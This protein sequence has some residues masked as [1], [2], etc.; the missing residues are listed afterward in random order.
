MNVLDLQAYIPFVR[1]SC[2]NTYMVP[3]VAPSAAKHL[4]T[5]T[6]REDS[7]PGLRAMRAVLVLPDTLQNQ[8]LSKQNNFLARVEQQ[9]RLPARPVGDEYPRRVGG[10]KLANAQRRCKRFTDSQSCNGKRG[11]PRQGPCSREHAH[12]CLASSQPS[13]AQRISS[14]AVS[15]VSGPVG[16]GPS[17]GDIA[18]SCFSCYQTADTLQLAYVAEVTQTKARSRSRAATD[19]D[20]TVRVSRGKLDHSRNA[21]PCEHI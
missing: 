6:T 20:L 18:S 5:Q 13:E 2:H 11:R 10:P 14:C 12:S 19:C 15:D 9:Q 21:R 17:E 1:L 3:P 8:I 4:A 16:S 7:R